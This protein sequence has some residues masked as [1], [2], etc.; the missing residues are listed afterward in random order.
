MRVT[1]VKARVR[2]AGGR[3]TDVGYV[4][5]GRRT[6]AHVE[7]YFDGDVPEFPSIEFGDNVTVDRDWDPEHGGVMFEVHEV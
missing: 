2:D 5:C 6:E 3:V 7:A 1:G 4:Q